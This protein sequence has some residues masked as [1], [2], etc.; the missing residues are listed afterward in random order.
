MLS[1]A[2]TFVIVIA[3]A[4]R[5]FKAFTA[6][7]VAYWGKGPVVGSTTWPPDPNDLMDLLGELDD[8]CP[9]AQGRTLVVPATPDDL[10][11]ARQVAIGLEELS[12][13]V[14][15]PE[16][17]PS[18]DPLVPDPPAPI[19][20][21]AL[22]GR[23]P[24]SVLARIEEPPVRVLMRRPEGAAAGRVDA[25]AWI[26]PEAGPGLRRAARLAA[27][28]LVVVRSGTLSAAELA[29]LQTRLGRSSSVG[30]LIIGLDPKHADLPDRA[31]VV[32]DF[33]GRPAE[34]SRSGVG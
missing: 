23:G 29:R 28:V 32:E 13:V 31:G 33:W 10:E 14:V 3:S 1:V 21:G 9:L 25:E 26:G 27:R 2:L 20:H 6:I 24:E 18:R 19:V 8:H 5:G 22:P 16:A 15:E 17:P 11:A 30:Y 34:P 12:A 4:L 7:E